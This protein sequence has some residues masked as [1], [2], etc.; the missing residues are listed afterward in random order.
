MKLFLILVVL[1]FVGFVGASL[2]L[3]IVETD[4]KV[5]FIDKTLIRD[6]LKTTSISFNSCNTKEKTIS[7]EDSGLSFDVVEI[8]KQDVIRVRAK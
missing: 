2:A 4:T 5:L 3:N 6:K 7:V 1:L 8:N